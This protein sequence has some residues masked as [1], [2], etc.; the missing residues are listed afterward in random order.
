LRLLEGNAGK[1]P[2]NRNE[3]QPTAP[4]EM[5]DIV[6]A[7]PAAA[8]EWDRVVASMPPGF[9]T[10]ADASVLTIHATSWAML[11][12]AWSEIERH[13]MTS[14]GSMG[15]PTA[16]PALAI[17]AK[18]SATLLQCADRLG[19]HP[20]ARAR[21]EM[22]YPIPPRLAALPDDDDPEGLLRG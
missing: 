3:P 5:P 21:L 6:A 18:Q 15:Q 16:H 10:A 22:P 1:R 12:R 8:K 20:G 4:L 19:L 7:D 13:G 2:I 11:L 14:R 17:I 9:F